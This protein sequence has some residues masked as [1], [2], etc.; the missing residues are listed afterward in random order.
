MQVRVPGRSADLAV[1]DQLRYASAV[2]QPADHQDG[3]LEA[4][5][6]PGPGSGNE[7]LPLPVQEA[8]Q[9]L[10]TSDIMA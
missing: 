3:L 1:G 4:T 2:D 10:D 9:S 8:G 7:P 5:Q 6:R